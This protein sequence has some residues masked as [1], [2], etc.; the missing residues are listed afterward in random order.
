MRREENIMLVFQNYYNVY[1]S[2]SLANSTFDASISS[3]QF[4]SELEDD[5]SSTLNPDDEGARSFNGVDSHVPLPVP[6][7]LENMGTLLDI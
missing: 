6:T 5:V 2:K 7:E 3:I 4:D 1:T